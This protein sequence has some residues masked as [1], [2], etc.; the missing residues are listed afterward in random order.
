MPAA[1]AADRASRARAAL[2][3]VSG[4]L[5]TGKV[6]GAARHESDL[7]EGDEDHASWRA[8]GG[9]QA[10]RAL[11]LAGYYWAQLAC[12]DPGGH[13]GPCGLPTAP[14]CQGPQVPK[15]EGPGD[16]GPLT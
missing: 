1:R 12:V 6:S 2:G 8:G 4:T 10:A 9:A 11:R 7:G 14:A 5:A 16:R 15:T 13:V 3:T